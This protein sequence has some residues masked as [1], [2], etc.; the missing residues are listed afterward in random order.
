MENCDIN[1]VAVFVTVNV[2]NK[3]VFS[4]EWKIGAQF[5]NFLLFDHE[6]RSWKTDSPARTLVR[7]A[8]K[9]FEMG[10]PFRE[11]PLSLL[12]GEVFVSHKKKHDKMLEH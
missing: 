6:L 10:F 11:D 8:Y 1:A 7:L 3:K 4:A 2:V 5:W 9:S 12:D